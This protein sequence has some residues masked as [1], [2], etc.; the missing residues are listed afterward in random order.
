MVEALILTNASRTSSLRF[1]P[2]C[3]YCAA[4]ASTSTRR[5]LIANISPRLLSVEPFVSPFREDFFFEA[6]NPLHDDLL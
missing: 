5:S 6:T 4:N 2:P 3:R 1:N